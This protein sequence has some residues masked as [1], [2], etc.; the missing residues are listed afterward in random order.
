MKDD[1]DEFI[2]SLD[3]NAKNG[4]SKLKIDA[5]ILEQLSNMDSKLMQQIQ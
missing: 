3:E 5:K 2:V 1:F 4:D